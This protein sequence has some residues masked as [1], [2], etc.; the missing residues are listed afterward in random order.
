MVTSDTV[1]FATFA[2][3]TFGATRPSTHCLVV[4]AMHLFSYRG[5]TPE[6]RRGSWEKATAADVLHAILS[7]AEEYRFCCRFCSVSLLSVEKPSKLKPEKR[8]EKKKKT[9]KQT[10]STTLPPPVYVVDVFCEGFLKK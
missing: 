8:K 1:N 6:H 7:V 2:C 9:K 5:L 3:R 4:C 10:N